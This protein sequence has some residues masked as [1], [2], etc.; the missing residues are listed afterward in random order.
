VEKEPFCGC[1]CF[2]DGIGPVDMLICQ[3]PVILSLF[4]VGKSMGIH[5]GVRS[6]RSAF[7]HLSCNCCRQ[8]RIGG[9]NGAWI[10]CITGLLGVALEFGLACVSRSPNS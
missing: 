4:V 10:V 9:R 7:F 2:E 8:D 5:V 1:W 6:K 3:N